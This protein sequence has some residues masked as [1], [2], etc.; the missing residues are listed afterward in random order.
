[1]KLE[2]FSEWCKVVLAL[3]IAEIALKKISLQDEN[4]DYCKETI[5][6]C[7]EWYKVKCIPKNI[8]CEMISNDDKCLAEIVLETDDI[9]EA[10]KYGT[11]LMCISYVAWQ[12]YNFDGDYYYPQNLECVDDEYLLNLIDDLIEEKFISIDQYNN[13]MIYLKNNCNDTLNNIEKDE[14]IKRTLDIC[15]ES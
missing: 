7:W 8:I 12:A 1:M 15:K 6:M 5:D 2:G 3:F 14:I 9:E 13:I 10:N 4:F 11:I